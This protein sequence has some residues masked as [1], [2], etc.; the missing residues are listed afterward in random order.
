MWHYNNKLFETTPEEYQGFVYEITEIDTGKKY[1]GK[2]NFWKPKTLPITK[3]VRDAYEHVLNLTGKN[4]TDHQMKYV[5]LWN[6][7]ERKPSVERS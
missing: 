4:I 5:D 1:I 6:H 7:E 3:H 2:K